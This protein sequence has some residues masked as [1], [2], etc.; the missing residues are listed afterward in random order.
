MSTVMAF[1]GSPIKGGSIEQGLRA[2]LEATELDYELVRLSELNMKVCLGCKGCA[3]TNRC[4]FQD[5]V[6]PLLEKI[7]GAKAL[8]LSGYPS[9]SSVNALTKVF[10]ERNWPLR[11]NH[12]M[13]SGKVG[14]AVICGGSG[15]EELAG[16]F[17]LYFEQYL[18]TDYAGTLSLAGNVPC[19][20]CGY[21]ED[22]PGSG[23]L[24]QYGAGARITPDKF[25][26][27]AR[28]LDAQ[29]RAAS[30]GEAVAR[31]VRQAA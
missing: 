23:F 30:L 4:V 24:R 22:C 5:D 13:T 8:V 25:F 31:A 6:N 9:F 1:S 27:F 19:L 21:G 14:A 2:V 17:Q 26:S 10:M 7:E 15:M 11:H 12:I 29:R 18:R 16:Y 20:S 3:S 28:D